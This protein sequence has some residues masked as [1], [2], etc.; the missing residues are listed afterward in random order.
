M[1]IDG[2]ATGSNLRRLGIL[3][4]LTAEG[5]MLLYQVPCPADVRRSKSL[6]ADD[7]AFCEQNRS[8][9]RDLHS[10]GGTLNFGRQYD[11]K[12]RFS[13]WTLATFPRHASNG[14]I[15]I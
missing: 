11:R 13:S 9:F 5:S 12:R 1:A 8:D 10:D 6:P 3:A 15:T 2:E 4:A 7:L 14:Q